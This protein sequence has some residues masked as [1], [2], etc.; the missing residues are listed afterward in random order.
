MRYAHLGDLT[1]GLAL[2]LTVAISFGLLYDAHCWFPP[3]AALLIQGLSYPLWSW[4][5]LRS[6]IRSLFEEEERAQVILN[7]SATP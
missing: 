2:L 3:A 7:P 6:A 1:A 5:R 4:R